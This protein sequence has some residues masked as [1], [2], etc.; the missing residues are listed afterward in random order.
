MSQS[1]NTRAFI[2]LSI[3]LTFSTMMLTSALM[4]INRHNDA[5]AMLH[6]VLGFSILVLAL[7]HMKNNLAPLLRYFKNRRS[8]AGRINWALPVATIMSTTIVLLSLAQFGPFMALYEWGNIL[9]TSDNSS[10]ASQSEITYIQVDNSTAEAL[11]ADITIDF[12]KGSHFTW[13]QYAIWLETMEGE[14]V[15]PLFITSKL[16]DNNFVNK[17][18]KKNAQQVLTSNPFTSKDLNFSDVFDF[19][20]EPASKGQRLRPESLPVFLHQLGLISE[21]GLHVP[22]EKDVITDAYTGATMLSNFLYT[23]NTSTVLHGEYRLRFE[24]NQSFDFNEYYSSDRF[25][26]DAIYSGNGYSAQPSVIYETIIDFCAQQRFYVMTPI[27]HGHHSGKDGHVYPSLDKLS[28][29][30]DVV[31]RIIVEVDRHS[32]EPLM[33][34]GN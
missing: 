28:T 18:T 22:T 31:D 34:S 13:P 15:Q 7:W 25:P 14:F 16:A 10:E 32:Q 26:D 30:L 20:V 23:S 9:R 8:K 5:T 29:A 12:R 17:V 33:T 21:E 19:V 11:G 3:F 4:F 27:G 1:A 24:I 6:T 2:T